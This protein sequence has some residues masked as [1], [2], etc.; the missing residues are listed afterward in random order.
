MQK[1]ITDAIQTL[2]KGGVIL[3]PSDTVWGLAC[4]A[5]ND[6]A[7]RRLFEI[8]KRALTKSILI[9]IQDITAIKKYALIPFNT[10]ILASFDMPT[11]VLYPYKSGLSSLL[12][13]KDN[14]IAARIP[15]DEF[16]QQLLAKFKKP[17]ASTSANIS[18][19][20]LPNYYKEI[21]HEILEKA[22][23]IVPMKQEDYMAIP[24]QIVKVKGLEVIQIR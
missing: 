3:Y 11:T 2:E 14:T 5:T 15:T 6:K 4:D 1:I 17:I 21:S 13:A 19:E 22:A 20:P 18:G 24:S 12:V 23:Y 10:E 7:V 8:K 9:Q 16:T